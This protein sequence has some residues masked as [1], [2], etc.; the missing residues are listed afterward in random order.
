MTTL[1]KLLVFLAISASTLHVNEAGNAI[2]VNNGYQ[3]IT[4]AI[5]SSIDQSQQTNIINYLQVTVTNFANK[6]LNHYIYRPINK[7]ILYCFDSISGSF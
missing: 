1:K 6:F 7:M 3:N 2:L 4:V 5:S